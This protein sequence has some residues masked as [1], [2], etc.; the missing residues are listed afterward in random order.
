M[1][2]DPTQGYRRR[3]RRGKEGISLSYAARYRLFCLVLAA[4][5]L[6]L[7]G[8][9]LA[10]QGLDP[11]AV[12]AILTV[13]AFLLLFAFTA[14]YESSVRPLQTLSNVVSSL[15]EEDYSF[16]ARGGHGNDPMSELSQEINALADMLQSQR[17]KALEAVALLQRVMVEM[18]APLLAFDQKNALR[19]LNPAAARAFG[20][21][22]VRDL[23]KSTKELRLEGLLSLPDE[24]VWQQESEGRLVRWMVR[25]SRFRQRGAPHT[26]LLLSDVSSALREEEQ[27]AW[28][29]LIRV[30]GHEIS[31]S[32]API[33]SI[34]GSLR[35]RI[36]AASPNSEL[37][38]GL[39]VIESR[40][41]SLHRFVQSYR[42]LA[43]LPQPVFRP[44]DLAPMIAR[45]AQ[46]EMRLPVKLLEVPSIQISVDPDQME[47]LLINLVR[48]AVEAAQSHEDD[49]APANVSTEVTISAGRQGN[50]VSILV[51]D[52]GP[53]IANQTNLFVPFYTTKKSGSGV[54]LAL[55][56]QIAEAHGG[57]LELRNR[58]DAKGCLAELRLPIE[59][60]VETAGARD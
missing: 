53:G 35:G 19:L 38:R 3:Y 45:V 54:G 46:L 30:L 51:A 31:N 13:I 40:A 10:R 1:A 17:I 44:V 36:A 8:A 34:A 7:T 57:T 11:A 14:F 9:V 15:R 22:A 42:Q 59:R 47:Q 55:A 21:H 58:E 6:S 50:V 60:R 27:L 23:G 4:I 25:R 43:Q 29:R 37:D 52:T 26:L 56:R 12:T 39:A 32:L 5:L 20:I 41:E 2:S 24:G 16:R 49:P 33:K 28:K 48:N 18:D